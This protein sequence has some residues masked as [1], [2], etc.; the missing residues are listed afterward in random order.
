MLGYFALRAIPGVEHVDAGTYRRTITVDGEP[1]VLELAPGGK[2]HLVLRARVSTRRGLRPVI[3]RARRVF[4]L[5]TD[6][7]D[8]VEHLSHDAVIGPL[9]QRRPGLRVPGTWDPFELGVRAIIGQQV[10]V[11]GAT[12]ITGRVVQRLGSPVDHCTTGLTHFFPSAD[13]LAEADLDGVG[14]TGARI[15]AIRG[16]AAAVTDGRV[17]LDR[18]VPL[19]EMIGAITVLPGLGPWTAG[20]LALRLG[21]P[22][23]FPAA[24]LGLQR[25]STRPARRG[26]AALTKRAEAWRPWRAL[27][28]VHLWHADGETC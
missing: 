18:T 20:Y 22:D 25:G 12:T 15:T 21:Y 26:T 14:L 9:V 4:A 2:N 23:A 3:E 1:G 5:D 10:T 8:A 11:A 16:F 6:G 7:T 28:A 24:D 17:R 13:V 27:A 19:E